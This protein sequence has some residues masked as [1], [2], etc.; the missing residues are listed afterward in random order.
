VRVCER[1]L[2]QTKLKLR[3]R[4]R[5]RERETERERE[6]ERGIHMENDRERGIHREKPG[7]DRRM[8]QEQIMIE[9]GHT[10]IY[11][12]SVLGELFLSFVVGGG[13]FVIP[14]HRCSSSGRWLPGDSKVDAGPRGLRSP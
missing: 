11:F 8:K 12:F 10:L 9:K 5:Q 2:R 13:C 14:H 6:R 3:E 7:S 4:E 1:L